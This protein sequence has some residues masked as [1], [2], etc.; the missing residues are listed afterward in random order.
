M[1]VSV[2]EV[3]CCREPDLLLASPPLKM[4]VVC[5]GGERRGGETPPPLEDQTPTMVRSARPHSCI[6]LVLRRDLSETQDQVPGAGLCG[7]Q[8]GNDPAEATCPP[9]ERFL[10][11]DV[12]KVTLGEQLKVT[13]IMAKSRCDPECPYLLPSLPGLC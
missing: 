2:V 12:W 11:T 9:Q 8:P 5:C 10:G 3:L 4:R 7:P 1:T 6:T 13:V